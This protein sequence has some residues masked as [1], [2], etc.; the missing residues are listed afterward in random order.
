MKD[1]VTDRKISIMP[2]FESGCNSE[3]QELEN[4]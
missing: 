4:L 2:R 1:L 3:I